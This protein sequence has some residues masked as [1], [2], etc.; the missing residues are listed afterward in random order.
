MKFVNTCVEFSL[1]DIALIKWSSILFG[2]ILGAFVHEYVRKNIWFFA[3]FVLLLAI[4]PAYT[5]FTRNK[6]RT[7]NTD[8]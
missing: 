5:H 2:M 6:H 8:S 4:K 3:F 1:I 7:K